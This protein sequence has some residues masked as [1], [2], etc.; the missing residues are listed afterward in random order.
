M[1]RTQNSAQ[2]NHDDKKHMTLELTVTQVGTRS[3][4]LRTK[5]NCLWRASFLM[6]YSTLEQRVP[7]GSRASRTWMTTSEESITLYSSPQIRFDCPFWK[8]LSLASSIQS[9]I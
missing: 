5:I 3:H 9:V 6:W 7:M 4:L 2:D 1:V 8:T